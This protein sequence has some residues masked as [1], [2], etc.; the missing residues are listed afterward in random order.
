M[1]ASIAWLRTQREHTS[2][3]NT[4]RTLLF[5]E[6][7]ENFVVLRSLKSAYVEST[8]AF[9][10]STYVNAILAG[11]RAVDFRPGVGGRGF[12]ARSGR[13]AARRS[14]PQAVTQRALRAPG[15]IS[16]VVPYKLG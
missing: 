3:A 4:E 7:R 12:S 1:R 2:A 5:C 11:R 6:H 16:T 13:A 10:I 9:E 15:E 8:D 14:V